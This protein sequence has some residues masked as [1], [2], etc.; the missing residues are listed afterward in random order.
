M[1][2]PFRNGPHLAKRYCALIRSR[3][4]GTFP[5]GR[6]VVLSL[7]H[8]SQSIGYLRYLDAFVFSETS[9]RNA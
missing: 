2:D 9:G 6:S 7:R 5:D 3:N 8:S 4:H 1:S